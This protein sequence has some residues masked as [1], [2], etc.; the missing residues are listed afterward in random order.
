LI[1][2]I[3]DASER[4][5]SRATAI[6]SFVDDTSIR[7]WTNLVGVKHVFIANKHGRCEYAAFVGWIHTAGLQQAI[8]V[9]IKSFRGEVVV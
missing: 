9:A 4:D 1:P 7:V 2:G 6:F 8:E 5:F 3:S